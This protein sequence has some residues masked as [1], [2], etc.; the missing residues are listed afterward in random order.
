MFDLNIFFHIPNLQIKY[1]SYNNVLLLEKGEERLADSYLPFSK[2]KERE[3]K[4]QLWVTY[5]AFTNSVISLN[6]LLWKFCPKAQ[7]LY[8]KLCE[9]TKFFVVSCLQS[10]LEFLKYRV[11]FSLLFSCSLKF[12]PYRRSTIANVKV[13]LT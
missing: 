8:R 3:K 7:F 10:L 9:I 6:F 4:N 13:T 12:I 2:I 1:N 5:S 11:W